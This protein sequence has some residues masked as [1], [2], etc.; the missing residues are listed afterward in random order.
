MIIQ[1]REFL[2][3]V[4]GSALL[5]VLPASTLFAPSYAKGAWV[6]PVKADT[7]A[8][9]QI[10]GTV[11]GR[12]QELANFAVSSRQLVCPDNLTLTAAE[13]ICVENV[14]LTLDLSMIGFDGYKSWRIWPRHNEPAVALFS[15]ESMT[16]TW[17]TPMAEFT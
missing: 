4:L 6:E 7:V 16:L 3:G 15:A 14:T 10:L 9:L 8:M 1:R 11:Q 13:A 5:P 2:T 17:E 12:H